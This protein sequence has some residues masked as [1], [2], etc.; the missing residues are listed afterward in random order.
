[1]STRLET[2]AIVEQIGVIIPPGTPS[3]VEAPPPT[4]VEVAPPTASPTVAPVG[5][6]LA[7]STP[8]ERYRNS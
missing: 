5:S 8:L 6:Q 4:L 2:N 1:V 7:T 3:V